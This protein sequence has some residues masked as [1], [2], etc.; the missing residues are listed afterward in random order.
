M[1]RETLAY[2]SLTKRDL[3]DRIGQVVEELFAAEHASFDETQAWAPV[4]I[5]ASEF[6]RRMQRYVVYN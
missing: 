4:P 2:K 3:D 1:S 6:I 5:D